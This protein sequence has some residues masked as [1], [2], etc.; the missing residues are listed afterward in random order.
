MLSLNEIVVVESIFFL[1]ELKNN[2]QEV[3]ADVINSVSDPDWIRIQMG[4]RIRIQSQAGENC[5]QKKGKKIKKLH[6]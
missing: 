4:Q 5:S 1:S 3:E 6:I 2:C